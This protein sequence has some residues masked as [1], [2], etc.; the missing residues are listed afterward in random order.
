MSRI[1]RTG[2][3]MQ[4]QLVWYLMKL[5]GLTERRS[6]AYTLL[7]TVPIITWVTRCGDDREKQVPNVRGEA[8]P[9]GG[10]VARWM[11]HV[12]AASGRASSLWIERPVSRWF[13]PALGYPE[14]VADA[15]RGRPR[16]KND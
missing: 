13:G 8:L 10:R 16:R 9:G 12:V 3:M 5:A 2:P 4:L 7:S 11:L 1:G 15:E 14:H 6:S